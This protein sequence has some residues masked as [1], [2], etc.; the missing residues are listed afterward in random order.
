MAEHSEYLGFLRYSG[1]PLEKGYMGTRQSAEALLG[2]D[3]A[4]RYFVNKQDKELAN[5][6]YDIPVRVKKGSWEALIPQD[7]AAYIRPALAIILTS[8]GSA[9]AAKMAQNDFKDASL[10]AVFKKAVQAIQ[11]VIKIGKHLGT[12]TKQKFENLEWKDGNQLIGILNEKGERLFVPAIFLEFYEQ[13]PVHLLKKIASIVSKDIKLE[14]VVRDDNKDKSESLEQT[15]KSI[16]CPDN[17]DEL[18]PELKHGQEVEL[19]GTV[20]R[21]NENTNNIGFQYKGHI[22]TC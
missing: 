8:Y 4:L 19:E 21:G 1:K 2:L 3:E 22:L 18:F 5:F 12:L 7:I 16:F 6:D 15:H 14:I 17:S 13:M 20:T 10:T 11:W 9:A